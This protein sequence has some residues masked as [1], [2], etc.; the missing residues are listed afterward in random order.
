MSSQC[1]HN[2]MSVL[3]PNHPNYREV[4]WGKVIQFR[5]TW[6]LQSLCQLNPIVRGIGTL[7]PISMEVKNCLKWKETKIGDTPIFHWNMIMGGREK[8]TTIIYYPVLLGWWPIQ[9]WWLIILN[10]APGCIPNHSLPTVFHH[11]HWLAIA[12][13]LS[14]LNRGSFTIGSGSQHPTF[15]CV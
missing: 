13:R 14:S 1:H 5:F 2:F 11:I 3:L 4:L 9:L 8:T 12:Y 10:S 15:G 7:S 6:K